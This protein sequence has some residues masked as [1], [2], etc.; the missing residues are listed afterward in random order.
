[1]KFSNIIKPF[2]LT[3]IVAMFPQLLSAYDFKVD[4]LC[5]NYND[6]GT[7]VTV[8][9]QKTDSYGDG[10]GYYYLVG[11]L[12]IPSSVTYKGK[13]YSV[14][15]IDNGAFCGC[16]GLTS[17]TIP[18]SVTSIGFEAFLYCSGLTSVDLGNSV[19]WIREYAFF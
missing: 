8:T 14:T 17:V 12:V 19:T 7:S 15:S 6:D 3:L 18:N 2:L 5:Y 11:N 16:N 10:D 4:G 1:M 9:Y 13:S